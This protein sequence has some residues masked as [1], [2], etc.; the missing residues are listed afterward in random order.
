MSWIKEGEL[1][2]IERISAN[3]LK[4]GPMP[5]HVAFIM[6]GNRRFAHI[7]NMERQDGHTQGFNKLAETLRWCKHLNIPEVTVYAFSIE[8]FKRTQEEVDGLMDLAR[9]KFERLLEER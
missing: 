3:V 6:D 4:A 8:N 9:Q 7:N 5:K 1:N 2:I